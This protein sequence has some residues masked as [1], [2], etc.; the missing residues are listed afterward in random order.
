L[1]CTCRD[2]PLRARLGSWIGPDRNARSLRGCA[3]GSVLSTATLPCLRVVGRAGP[4][5]RCVEC[6]TL[7]PSL[8][9][10]PETP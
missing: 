6:S 1:R 2:S 3:A 7:L 9:W 8:P 5:V 10:P 4:G